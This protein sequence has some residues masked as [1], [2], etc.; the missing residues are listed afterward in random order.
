MGVVILGDAIHLTVSLS[1]VH[2]NGSMSQPLYASGEE[3][4]H[5]HDHMD[6]HGVWQF[7]YAATC[8]PLSQC[9]VR[10]VHRL[11]TFP[12]SICQYFVDGQLQSVAISFQMPC[13]Y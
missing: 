10:N 1:Q 6:S 11:T 12:I 4:F 8:L 7:I 5:L 13:V 2:M 9:V 3:R